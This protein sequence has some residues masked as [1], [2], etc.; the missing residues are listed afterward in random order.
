MGKASSSK[1]V[2]KAARAGGSLRA[3][4]DRKWGFPMAIAGIVVAG[5][6]LVAFVRQDKVN[7]ASVPPTLQDHWH[8]AYSVYLCDTFAPPLSDIGEDVLGIHTHADGLIHIHP[9]SSNAAGENAQWQ[10]FGDQIGLAFDEGSFTMPTGEEY[11]NGGECTVT[12]DPTATTSTTGSTT[13]TTGD[14][15]TTTGDTT[16]TTVGTTTTAE[17][18]TEEAVVRL[19]KWPSG[20]YEGEPEILSGDLGDVRF[21]GDGE[22]Y[23]LFYGPESLLDDPK[24]LLPPSLASINDVSDLAPGEEAPDFSVPEDIARPSTSTTAPTGSSTT[25]PDGATTTAP[26]GSTAPVSTEPETT[27]TTAG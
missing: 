13:S 27:A 9:F 2:A 19:L 5:A 23:T 16:T 15:T 26:P 17:V 12:P 8:A 7:E 6:S 10:V 11:K 14:T 3:T 24:K 22:A 20:E 18:V 25:A 1:K 4:R 21:T